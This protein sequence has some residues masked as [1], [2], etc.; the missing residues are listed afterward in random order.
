M[1]ERRGQHLRSGEHASD[2]KQ[3]TA[4]AAGPQPPPEFR[5][6]IAP[7]L[8]HHERADARRH[9]SRQGP[10]QRDHQRIIRWVRGGKTGQR[11]PG[12]TE[13][14]TTDPTQEPLEC[15]RAA[16]VAKPERALFAAAVDLR[17]ERHADV[18][19]SK[20]RAEKP[21]R[22]ID[23]DADGDEGIAGNE[24]YETGAH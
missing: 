18:T 12:A 5:V 24:R 17:L 22:A 6:D 8:Q 10:H 2:A 13:A 20:S 4:Y 19:V 3:P 23:E 1:G 9:P 16:A 15:R 21:A 7:A 14:K 11:K